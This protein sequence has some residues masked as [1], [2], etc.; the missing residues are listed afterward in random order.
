MS[1]IFSGKPG[2]FVELNDTI[3]GFQALLSGEGDAF[4]ENSFYMVGDLNEAF[5]QGRKMAAE[6]SENMG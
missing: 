6:A 4:P 3:S 2:K 1:E 5:E